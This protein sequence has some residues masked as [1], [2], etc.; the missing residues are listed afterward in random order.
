MLLRRDRQIRID[1]I[2]RRRRMISHLSELIR[3]RI[4]Q[5][6]KLKFGVRYKELAGD[7][8]GVSLCVYY[9]NVGTVSLYLLY[10]VNRSDRKNVFYYYSRIFDR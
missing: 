8:T 10:D 4:K 7:D 6:L 1:N 2:K 9:V 3:L 5:G